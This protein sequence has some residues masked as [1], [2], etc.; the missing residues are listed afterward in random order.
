MRWM[1]VVLALAGYAGSAGAGEW[2]VDRQARD[3]QVRFVSTVAGFSFAGKTDRI[4]GYAWW[5]GAE[6]FAGESRLLFEVELDGLD[7]GIGKRD[8]DMRK[9]LA[10][11]RWPKAV[12]KGQILR[13]EPVDS[14]VTAYRVTVK[15]R[16]SLHG[17]ER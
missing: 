3:N 17:V 2:Q 5:P 14:T 1:L 8:R 9:V 13:Y 15:G 10:T 4:D 16:C 6:L 7:T 11:D 12:F